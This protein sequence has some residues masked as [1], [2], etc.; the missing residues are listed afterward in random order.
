MSNGK[1]ACGGSLKINGKIYSF[2]ENGVYIPMAQKPKKSWKM[3]EKELIETGCLEG[4]TRDDSQGPLIYMKTIEISGIEGLHIYCFMDD[5][6][7]GEIYSFAY[8]EDNLTAVREYFTKA[9]GSDP[10]VISDTYLEFYLWELSSS[11]VTMVYDSDAIMLMLTEK[12]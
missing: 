5:K 9:Y 11:N 12:N 8:S 7:T 4:Y 1:A 10:Y 3:S 2:D 6:F